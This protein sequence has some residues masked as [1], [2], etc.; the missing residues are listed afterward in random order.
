M[1][2]KIKKIILVKLAKKVIINEKLLVLLLKYLILE[3]R[4]IYNKK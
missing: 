2:K 1:K 3:K 4:L